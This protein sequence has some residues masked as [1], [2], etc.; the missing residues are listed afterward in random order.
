MLSVMSI[1]ATAD[2]LASASVS[3]SPGAP[4]ALD[5]LTVESRPHDRDAKPYRNLLKAITLDAT[6]VARLALSSIRAVEDCQQ[7]VLVGT[8]SG[9][10]RAAPDALQIVCNLNR[11]A[12]GIGPETPHMDQNS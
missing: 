11:V 6:D 9:I 1:V 10:D 3:N 8:L 2:A 12:T 5:P 7:R 4:P